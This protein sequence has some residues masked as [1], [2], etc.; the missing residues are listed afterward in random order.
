MLGFSISA[1]KRFSELF[2]PHSCEYSYSSQNRLKVGSILEKNLYKKWLDRNISELEEKVT[3]R[4]VVSTLDAH[5]RKRSGIYNLMC[6]S[7]EPFSLM[8]FLHSD[9]NYSNKKSQETVGLN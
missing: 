8:N 5:L 6:A 1:Q 9:R 7:S 2:F 4:K 3:R